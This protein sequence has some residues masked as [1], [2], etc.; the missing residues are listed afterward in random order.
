MKRLLVIAVIFSG[1]VPA[2]RQGKGS[3]RGIVLNEEGMAIKGATVFPA[4]TAD[5]PLGG[6]LLPPVRTDETGISSFRI[7][8]SMNMWFVATTKRRTIQ[9]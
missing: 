6:R 4:S 1:T 8:R 2:R 5:R 9:S 3:I 7:C